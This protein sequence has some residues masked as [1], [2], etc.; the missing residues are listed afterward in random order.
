MYEGW[1]EQRQTL[2]VDMLGDELHEWITYW[3]KEFGV[4]FMQGAGQQR[5]V[6]NPR[7][8]FKKDFLLQQP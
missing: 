6:Q 1:K 5:R 3:N 4:P 7:I 2:S 8:F